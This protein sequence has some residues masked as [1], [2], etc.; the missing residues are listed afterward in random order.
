VDG[1]YPP[2]FDRLLARGLEEQAASSEWVF[3]LDSWALT[4]I[5]IR[6]IIMPSKCPLCGQLLPHAIDHEML[7][8]R[9]QKL[10]SPALATERRRLK[11]E[12]DD[13]VNAAVLQ[14]QRDAERRIAAAEQRARADA[15][16][17]MARQLQDA[18][19]RVKAADDRRQAD[20]QR[21]RREA[22]V[23]AKK[24]N[25]HAMR[26]A[27]AQ[28]DARFQKFEADRERERSRDAERTASLQSK[29]D[30]LSRRLANQ[31]SEQLGSEAERDLLAELRAAFPL[32]D[33]KSIGRG[34][35]GADILHSVMDGSK[36]VGKIVYESKNTLQWLNEFIVQAK[37]YRTQYETSHVMIASRVLPGKQKGF[38]V[39]K[40]VPVI[41][42]RL[43]VALATIVREG[44]I[45]IAKLRVSGDSRDGKSQ[46]L[47]EYIVGEKF[48]A[49]FRELAEGV[50]SL[51]S[52]Q[53]AER[54]WHDRAWQ[55]ESRLHDLI[56][57]R[58]SEVDAQIRAICRGSLT[59]EGT[60]MPAR[61]VSG[62]ASSFIAS[63][64]R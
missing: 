16:R 32:D 8:S 17:D 14:S 46:E 13:R 27:A 48:C 4:Q 45:E 35:K 18:E 41:E 12:A 34:V 23:Q 5:I 47:Y 1:R 19:K 44:I 51:R 26:L 9:I 3:R 49:R 64:S 28:Y 38:C 6:T 7:Q 43:A 61:S 54:R 52:Q 53:Q 57:S 62:T 39:W 36:V 58:H 24:D 42:S 37:K 30:D 20:I 25:A 29:V 31:S 50:D 11:K 55:E 22:D 40:G 59:L 63:S 60:R 2:P 21:A 33:L 10:S 56:A 15:K